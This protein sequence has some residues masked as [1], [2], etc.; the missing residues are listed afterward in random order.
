MG[1]QPGD[2][3]AILA[4]RGAQFWT[5]REG[6]IIWSRDWQIIDERLDTCDHIKGLIRERRGIL[7]Q[8][9]SEDAMWRNGTRCGS[10]TYYTSLATGDAPA[11][12][13]GDFNQELSTNTRLPP[14]E[15]TRRVELVLEDAHRF[16]IL[17]IMEHTFFCIPVARHVQP[18]G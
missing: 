13:R 16:L 5:G 9:Q 11:H 10:R 4:W 12:S 8:A 7:C 17:W 15:C 3:D 6:R 1:A 2:I 18:D 14:D